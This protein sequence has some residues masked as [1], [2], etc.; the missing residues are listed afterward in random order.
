[1]RNKA[2]I[3][4]L[5]ALPAGTIRA[6]A[7]AMPAVPAAPATELRGDT[8]SLDDMEE[9][10]NDSIGKSRKNTAT[11]FNA[12]KYVLDKR[13]HGYGDEFTGKWDDHLYLLF[14]LGATQMVPPAKDYHFNTLTTVQLGVGKEFNEHSSLR[15]ILQNS[16]GYQQDRDITLNRLGLTAEHLF[17]LSSYFTGYNPTR[18]A[19]FSTIVGAGAHWSKFGKGIRSGMSGELHLGL[20][21]RFFTGPQGYF[22]IEPYF[23]F[24]TDKMDLNTNKNWRKIDMFYGAN[25]SYVYY[26]HNNLSPQARL[27]YMRDLPDDI[28]LSDDKSPQPAT[29]RV[30]WLVEFSTGLTMLSSPAL[31]TGETMGN[32]LAVGVG[33][34]FSPVVGLRLTGALS[35]TRWNKQPVT[36]ENGNGGSTSYVRNL[37]NAYSGVRAEAMF[38]PLGFLKDFSWDSD[39]GAYIVA[40]GMYG[41]IV[42]Y[43]DERLSCK[44]EAYTAGIHLWKKL[45]DGLHLFVEPR[46]THYIYKIPYT[47]VQWNKRFSDDGYSVNIGLSVLTRRKAFRR[48]TGQDDKREATLQGRLSIGLGGGFNIIQTKTSYEG[49]SSTPYNGVVFG[50]YQFNAISSVNASFEYMSISRGT[51]GNYYDVNLRAENPAES[52]VPERG[53]LRNRYSLGLISIG[54]GID[55]GSLCNGFDSHR[56]FSLTAYA[57]PTAI[58]SLGRSTELDG[59][60]A[61]R[62]GH[63]IEVADLPK[64]KLGLGAHAGLQLSYRVKDN[65]SV[66]LKPT[67]YA[68]GSTDMPAVDFLK[69][70]FVESISIGV[71]YHFKTHVTKQI[72]R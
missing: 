60:Q 36:V 28:Q 61:V 25:L 53:L 69:V 49:T 58:L 19:E 54:Y 29:W 43:Q 35:V 21:M 24:A 15:L 20:Q 1:M 48:T 34:W 64:G 16:F 10:D 7:Y 17:S 26:L 23:G 39:L 37:N 68:L 14:G 42:K 31:S 4:L 32:E 9:S 33:K 71:Q 18:L 40:G 8:I 5:L 59:T 65:L 51:I 55:L 13:Y 38:N 47:N 41:W 30:P 72:Y 52:R 22:N 11:N 2:A 46:Y 57:G 67:V 3:L 6:A 44:S 45:S 63:A 66:V 50:E 12:L 56:R 62:S 70:K 27:R